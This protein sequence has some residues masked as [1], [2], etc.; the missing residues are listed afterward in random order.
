VNQTPKNLKDSLAVI[1]VMLKLTKSP[2][3]LTIV[4]GQER[5]CVW[6][7]GF[8]LQIRRVFSKLI[9]VLLKIENSW[10]MS[11]EEVRPSLLVAIKVVSSMNAN[12][13]MWVGERDISASKMNGE[14]SADLSIVNK[15]SK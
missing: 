11:S 10:T 12:A 3:M 5:G 13:E 4:G 14:L 1:G 9:F 8:L 7:S 2:L 15:G 6:S